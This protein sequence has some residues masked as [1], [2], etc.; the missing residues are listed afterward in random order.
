MDPFFNSIY[1]VATDAVKDRL[2]EYGIFI[3]LLA[4]SGELWDGVLATGCESERS[5]LGQSGELHGTEELLD[6]YFVD[7]GWYMI[8]HKQAAELIRRMRVL[9]LDLLEIS[10]VQ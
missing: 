8:A 7:D 9:R 10:A 4:S 5:A 6:A 3:T 1:Q 2:R